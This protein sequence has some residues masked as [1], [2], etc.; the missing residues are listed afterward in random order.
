MDILECGDWSPLWL[1]RLVAVGFSGASEIASALPVA[2]AVERVIKFDAASAA[3]GDKSPRKSS[4]ESPHS[5]KRRS[6]R[7]AAPVAMSDRVFTGLK[8]DFKTQRVAL[9]P[10]RVVSS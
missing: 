2:R 8:K 9:E 6:K 3:D 10:R 4:D 7:C 5:K 1:R